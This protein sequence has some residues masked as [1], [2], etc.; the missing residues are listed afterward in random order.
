MLRASSEL[1][2]ACGIYMREDKFSTPSGIVNLHPSVGTNWVLYTN[3]HYFD[4]Y[5]C[6]PPLNIMIFF[7]SGIYSE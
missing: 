1:D 7:K 4:S 6:T 2:T 5:G 3:K